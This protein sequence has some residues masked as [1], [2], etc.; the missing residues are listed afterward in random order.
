MQ[1][2]EKIMLLKIVKNDFLRN[3]ILTMTVFIFITMAVILAA[4]AINN[5]VNLVQAMSDLQESAV[6]ADITVMHAGKYDQAEIDQI[7]RTIP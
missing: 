7:S 6:P 2:G 5:I 1:E 4:S 3:K